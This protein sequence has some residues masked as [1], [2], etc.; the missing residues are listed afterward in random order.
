M[1]RIIGK[2]EEGPDINNCLLA[3]RIQTLADGLRDAERSEESEKEFR[4]C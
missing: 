4:R 3:Y 2:T 1:E